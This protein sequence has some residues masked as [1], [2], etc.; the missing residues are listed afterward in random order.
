MW[1]T[2]NRSGGKGGG[3]VREG[4]GGG[5]VDQQ[6][7]VG[8][9]RSRC[10]LTTSSSSSSSRI[11][12]RNISRFKVFDLPRHLKL[13]LIASPSDNEMGRVSCEQAVDEN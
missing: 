7:G 2:S 10:P 9:L 6:E 13:F 8:L 3:R 12:F 11:R 4:G 1:C 5:A